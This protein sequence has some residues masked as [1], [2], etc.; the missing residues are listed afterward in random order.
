LKIIPFKK[1]YYEEICEWWKEH[2][3]EPVNEDI[4][5]FEGYVVVDEDDEKIICGWFV[6]TNSLTALLDWVVSNPKFKGKKVYKALTILE[7]HVCKL[8][9]ELGYKMI[10]NMSEHNGLI[11][12]FNK[13]K[14]ITTDKNITLLM[15]RL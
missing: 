11:N 6:R 10:M 14:W 8:A 9:D 15:K 12:F 2:S 5:S 1:S 13:K 7:D 3:W 4:L